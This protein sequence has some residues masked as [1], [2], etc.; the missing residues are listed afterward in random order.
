MPPTAQRSSLKKTVFYLVLIVFAIILSLAAGELAVRVSKLFGPTTFIFR[1]FDPVLGVALIP[2]TSGVHRRCY[3]GYVS[4]NRH[5]MRDQE[6]SIEKTEGT[7]RI[8][9]FSDSII[10]AVHVKPEE[11]ATS[12]L[13][14]HLNS[15]M[16]DGKCEVLNFAVGG[17]S[18]LQ[19]YLRYLRDGRRFDNDLVIV[20]LTDND[21]P[22]VITGSKKD[23]DAG[24]YAVGGMYPSPYLVGSEKSYEIM[25][26][27]KPPYTDFLETACRHSD[28]AYLLYKTYY[29]YLKPKIHWPIHDVAPAW[30]K[31]QPSYMFLDPE[32]EV[33]RQ[34]WRQLEHILDEFIKAVE[35]D[36][37]KFMLVHWGYDVGSNPWYKPIPTDAELPGS[38]DPH[39]ASKW[40]A[41]YGARKQVEV[42]NLSVDLNQYM[43]EK[44]LKE[45]YL[46]FSCDSHFNPEGQAV[47]AN[48][49]LRRLVERHLISVPAKPEPVGKQQ[50]QRVSTP[51]A[52]RYVDPRSNPHRTAQ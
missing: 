7:Y 20:V 35:E 15:E 14:K 5:G 12:V 10:E 40:F 6:R 45:P 18:P 19:Y 41:R 9:V 21:L 34:G 49:L 33:A 38:F 8:A 13:E 39:Y 44:G 1:T 27:V 37:A 50:T 51:G 31:V 3:D 16:C 36:G 11:T 23:S 29:I 43:R 26:P 4:I 46:S 32:N 17:Y 24:D 22:L 2:N 30:A 25:Q 48:S 47:V 28:L 42:L 52:D